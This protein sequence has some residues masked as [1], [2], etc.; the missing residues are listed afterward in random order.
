M[1]NINTEFIDDDAFLELDKVLSQAEASR[2]IPTPTNTPPKV[3]NYVPLVVSPPTSFSKP[4]FPSVDDLKSN[5]IFTK[6][7]S[8]KSEQTATFTP[9]N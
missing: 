3:G 2:K 8:D 5:S 9:K 6:V 7:G 1:S 4:N